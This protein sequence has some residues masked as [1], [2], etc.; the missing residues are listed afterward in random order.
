MQPRFWH[1]DKPWL[2]Q[3]ALYC[4]CHGAVTQARKVADEWEEKKKKKP[5]GSSTHGL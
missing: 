1:N 3:P 4:E 2:L 5:E